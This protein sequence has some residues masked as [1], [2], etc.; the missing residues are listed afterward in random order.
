LQGLNSTLEKNGLRFIT[1][2][3]SGQFVHEGTILGKLDKENTNE[4]ILS[5]IHKCFYK[6]DNAE[7]EGQYHFGLRKISEIAVKAL[8]PGINDQGTA[9]KAIRY[10]TILF[11]E[12][13]EIDNYVQLADRNGEI[14]IYRKQPDLDTLFFE[15]ISPIR[16]FSSNSLEIHCA[17]YDFFKILLMQN[18]QKTY[19]IIKN[20][21]LSMMATSDEQINN[22]HDREIINNYIEKIRKL[23]LN[24]INTIP[25]LTS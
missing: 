14:R 11:S 6:V 21:L 12:I 23:P 20:H 1:C 4:E 8:S 19:L 24:N 22:I 17:L 9:L 18:I 2:I 13:L 5:A 3:Y 16:Q 10:L 15:S 7:D 25:K